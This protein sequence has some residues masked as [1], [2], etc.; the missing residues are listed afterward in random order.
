MDKQEKFGAF[1]EN[2]FFADNRAMRELVEGTVPRGFLQEDEAYFTGMKDSLFASNPMDITMEL[3]E[4][5]QERYG[6]FCSVCHGLSGGGNG[7]VIQKGFTPATSYTDERILSFEDGEIFNVITNGVRT[8]PSLNTQI[9]V[10]DR[11]A[12]VAYVRALQRSQKASLED[13]PFDQRSKLKQEESD[14]K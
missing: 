7:I 13:V 6:I 11:W 14:G 12:I 3:L 5:G 4:R 2:P 1:G 8:M 10:D 9:P